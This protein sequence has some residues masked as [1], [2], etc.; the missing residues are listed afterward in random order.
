MAKLTAK[1]IRKARDLLK[2]QDIFLKPCPFCGPGQSQVSFY[3]DDYENMVVGCGRC[4]SHSGACPK[5]Y[6]NAP[7]QVIKLWNTRPM[8]N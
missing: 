6:P 5:K 4:G 7:A 3:E 1:D 8:E 2:K